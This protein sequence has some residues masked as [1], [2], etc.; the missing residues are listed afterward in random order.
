[1]SASSVRDAEATDLNLGVNPLIYTELWQ[2]QRIPKNPR[3]PPAYKGLKNPERIFYMHG[4]CRNMHAFVRSYKESFIVFI[5]GELSRNP[6][7]PSES[8]WFDQKPV[9][10][11]GLPPL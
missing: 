4:T 3:N 1:L 8:L 11:G 9:Y 2:S 7:E 6:P 5:L 10:T